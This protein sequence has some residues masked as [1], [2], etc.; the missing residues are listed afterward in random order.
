MEI[1][2]T[3][4]AKALGGALRIQYLRSQDCDAGHSEFISHGPAPAALDLRN[5][6]AALRLARRFNPDVVVFSLWKSVFAFLLLR[7]FLPG[8]RI[9]L[10]VH[11]AQSAHMIDHLVTAVMVRLSHSVWTDSTKSAQGRVGQSALRH[12]AR[13]IS[14]VRRRP[15]KFSSQC[16]RPSFLYWGRLHEI[17]RIDRAIELF[18]RIAARHKRARFKIVGPD[19]GNRAALENQVTRLGLSDRIEFVGP[20][21]IEAIEALAEEASFYVQ[22]SSQ[23]GAAMSVIEAMQFGL[24]PVVTPVGAIADYCVNGSNSILFD[25]LDNTADRIEEVLSEQSRYRKLRESAIA[26]W[27]DDP[28]YHDDLLIAAAEENN[29][30]HARP[31]GRNEAATIDPYRKLQ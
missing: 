27:S 25:D 7:F 1:V 18:S 31:D 13:V 11:S 30:R 3:Q 23:E 4:A 28:L 6:T 16:S 19:A 17:K 2:A 14:F 12:R 22:L 9:V 26:Q 24:V 8:P 10:F 5:A 29:R 15:S 20:M 21:A